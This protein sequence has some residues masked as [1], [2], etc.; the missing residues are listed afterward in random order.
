MFLSES[1]IHLVKDVDKKRR[2]LDNNVTLESLGLIQRKTSVEDSSSGLASHDS[3]HDSYMEDGTGYSGDD[4]EIVKCDICSCITKDYREN[5]SGTCEKRK[6]RKRRLRKRRRKRHNAHLHEKETIKA[7]EL[8]KIDPNEFEADLRKA[9]QKWTLE[10]YFDESLIPKLRRVV[11]DRGRPEDF[12]ID[13]LKVFSEESVDYYKTRRWR[14][15]IYSQITLRNNLEREE[16]NLLPTH[17]SCMS[18]HDQRRKEIREAIKEGK[19]FCIPAEEKREIEKLSDWA[20]LKS[21]DDECSYQTTWRKKILYGL[22]LQ[23]C[24]TLQ[25]LR[26]RRRNTV[27]SPKRRLKFGR[28]QNRH[29]EETSL[30]DLKEEDWEAYEIISDGEVVN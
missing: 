2:D 16:F 3:G 22:K 1:Y 4:E 11:I 14:N 26:S 24:Q 30:C 12:G 7:R 19:S 23:N 15:N 28:R 9:E 25:I 21:A 13:N 29:Y 10:C 17:M 18:C 20:I 6:N 27:S 5:G 8:P